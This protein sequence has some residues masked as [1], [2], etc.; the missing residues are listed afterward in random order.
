MYHNWNVPHRRT[1]LN[2]HCHTSG[3]LNT[4]RSF[5]DLPG[6]GQPNRDRFTY[7]P[8]DSPR[9]GPS[10]SILFAR[11][12]WT[13]RMRMRLSDRQMS[14][15]RSIQHCQASLNLGSRRLDRNTKTHGYATDELPNKIERIVCCRR[16]HFFPVPGGPKRVLVRATTIEPAR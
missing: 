13:R 5:I 9:K 16:R 8:Y 10:E 11:V 12:T 7:I 2:G 15:L 14:R 4:S 6:A 1:V 3:F